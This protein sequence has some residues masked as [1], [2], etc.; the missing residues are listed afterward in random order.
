MNKVEYA[1]RIIVKVPGMK[2]AVVENVPNNFYPMNQPKGNAGNIL[3]DLAYEYLR[4]I[5]VTQNPMLL[6][7]DD[8]Y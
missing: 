5:I 1:L 4:S 2:E 8:K 3:A 7:Y 6:G